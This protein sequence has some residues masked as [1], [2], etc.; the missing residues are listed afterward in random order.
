[1]ELF[2]RD[3]RCWLIW[4]VSDEYRFCNLH[5]TSIE[6]AWT[7][8]AL[9]LQNV[10]SALMAAFTKFRDIGPTSNFSEV[11][12]WW[13]SYYILNAESCLLECDI[14]VTHAVLSCSLM[15]T[16][17]VVCSPTFDDSLMVACSLS[18][19]A[20]FG[21]SADNHKTCYFLQIEVC[22]VWFVGRK[23]GCHQGFWRHRE[24]HDHSW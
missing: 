17:F 8:S 3:R 1:M 23:D 16:I 21:E 13:F 2:A 14:R 20:G 19:V 6:E 24:W 12:D 18:F 4:R 11:G 15:R 9:L 10:A 22:C 7:R 5:S